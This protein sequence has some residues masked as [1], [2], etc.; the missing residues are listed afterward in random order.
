MNENAI[1]LV[2]D[3]SQDANLILAAF[4]KWGVNNPIQVV[5]DG[6]R[7]VEYL[8]GQGEYADRDKHPLPCLALLDLHLPQMSGFEVLQWIRAQPNLTNLPVVVLSGTKDPSHFE[9]AQRLGANACVPKTLEHTALFELIQHLN[10]F[11]VASDYNNADV[12]WT[13]EP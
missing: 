5:L 3:S 9:E 1:L 6:E 12:P 8:G 4:K 2:E 10:Y 11:S 7:A 13:P